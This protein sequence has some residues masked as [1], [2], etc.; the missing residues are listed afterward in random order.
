MKLE[1][2]YNFVIKLTTN[3]PA[4]CKCCI[5]RKKEIK[6][7]DENN[8]TFDKTDFERICQCLKKMK[9]SYI[10]LSG[11]EPTIVSNIN[12]YFYIAH[13]NKLATRINTN[14]WNITKEKMKEWLTLGLEQI[15]LSIYSLDKTTLKTIRGNEEL[16][17]K[18]LNAAKILSEFRENYDFTFVIQTV[19][20][21]DNYNEMAEILKFAIENN[22]DIF[23][24]SYLE[25]AFNLPLIRMQKKDIAK[26]KKDIIP[27]MKMVIYNSWIDTHQSQ[28][29]E[30]CLDNLYRKEYNNYI[31]HDKSFKCNWL[32]KHLTF[33]PNGTVYP[34][35]GHDY[36]SS[37]IQYKIDYSKIDEL[38]IDSLLK[39]INNMPA[40]CKYCPQGVYQE[41]NLQNVSR[42]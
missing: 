34:C 3:C 26:F 20:M 8:K 33:Y 14:G 12:E 40:N 22:V 28:Y 18:S 38:F 30:V 19:I 11:G 10:C 16:L 9:G 35:P 6:L 27:K 31:Y 4:N 29:L 42:L 17:N 13:K 23:W 21:K 39:N 2:A 32:G 24:P 1:T 37:S 7:K 5:N 41:I 25:D 36:F 15:V